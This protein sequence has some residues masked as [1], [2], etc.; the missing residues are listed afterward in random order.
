MMLY[1]EKSG[2]V[3]VFL[4]RAVN[5]YVI[6]AIVKVPCVCVVLFCVNRDH[7]YLIKESRSFTALLRI[8]EWTNG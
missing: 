1:A 3:C 8:K 6:P 4:A 7:P 2:V 5:I